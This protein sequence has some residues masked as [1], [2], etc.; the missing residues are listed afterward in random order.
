MSRHVTEQAMEW[1]QEL[2]EPQAQ[3]H[4]AFVD[5]VRA[6]PDHLR[7]FLEAMALNQTLAQVDWQQME[8]VSAM[9]DQ[10]AAN[11]IHLPHALKA[12]QSV[13][14]PA[15]PPRTRA[16]QMTR[17]VAAFAAVAATAAVW[18]A[19]TPHGQTYQTDI[20]EQRKVELADRS[21]VNL[22]SRSRIELRFSATAREVTLEG[23]ASFRVGTDARRPFRVHS[24]NA[25]IQAVGTEFNVRR[26]PSGTTVFVIEGRVR[27]TAAET[28]EL[29]AG[30]QAH[31]DRRGR[32]G[33]SDLS[34]LTAAAVGQRHRL[35]F[36]DNTLEDIAAEF[37]RWNRRQI[38]I[39]AD[40][41]AGQLYDGAFDADDPQSLIE[42]LRRMP[43][44][45]IEERGEKLLIRPAP[46]ATPAR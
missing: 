16:N 38:H 34:G 8:K 37:N 20:G 22:S 35:V 5:W 21:V 29:A 7:A 23:E 33:K 3:R 11:V 30:E 12:P 2:R 31:I 4:E 10:T 42:F 45:T 26:L 25:V 14:T 1:L 19:A 27:V 24:G 32:V 17:W 28:L 13:S 43:G 18:W 15:P 40:A 46:T 9:L 39:Q 41:G 6:S 44:L 36:R